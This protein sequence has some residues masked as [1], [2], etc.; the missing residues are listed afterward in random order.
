MR[1]SIAIPIYLKGK[2]EQPAYDKCIEHYSRMG[3]PVVVCGSEGRISFRFTSYHASN[4]VSY[5]EVPQMH[6]T[7]ASAGDESLRNKFNDSL[8][9]LPD[10]DWYCLVGADDFVP[11][12]VFE[13]LENLNPNEVIMAGVR[14]G[15]PLMVY[16]LL[17]DESMN[18][19]LSYKVDLLP[20]VNIFSKAA[21]KAVKG[22]PYQL[23]GC[24]T[25]AEKLFA[26]IGKVVGLD[27]YV[28][29]LKY[30]DEL[31]TYHKIKRVHHNVPLTKQQL[32]QVY[33]CIKV[34]D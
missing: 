28:V 27:G 1:V 12:P 10:S 24:E 9:A 11:K 13:Q 8:A 26:D 4:T 30:K 18:V 31:N 16:N 17:T 20:G 5:K 6:G 2:G 7:I 15:Q 32:N 14:S 21:M 33:E 34:R 22:R 19:T 29:M 3:Y 25:G 23:K